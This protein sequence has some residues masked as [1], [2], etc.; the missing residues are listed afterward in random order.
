LTEFINFTG[1]YS[2]QASI[3]QSYWCI[4]STWI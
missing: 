2:L 3:Q 4:F 1:L